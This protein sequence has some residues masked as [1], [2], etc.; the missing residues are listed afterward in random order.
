MRRLSLIL[1]ALILVSNLFSQDSPHGDKLDR[2]CKECHN[3][4]SWKLVKGTYPFDHNSVRFKLEGQHHNV[5]C[6]SCHETLVFNEAKSEC[7]SCHTDMHEQT[8][9]M[10]CAR[11]H[12]PVSWIVSNINEIHEVS[13]FPLLGAHLMA[14]CYSCHT[15]YSAS[16]LNFEPLGVEC[17]D[18]HLNN[19][20]QTTS[21][22]HVSGNFSTDCSECHDLNAFTF[23]GSGIIHD[24][25]PL[26]QG[27]SISDC[28]AC[29][30]EG[31]P[32]SNISAECI[33]CHQSDFN[34]TTNPNHVSADLSTN[35]YDC[36][37]LAKGWKP[38][39]F[40]QHDPLYFPI[41]SGK[42][43]NE[44]NN[45]SD[46]HEVSS[47]YAQYTC[48]S[49]H[50]HNQSEMD[51]KH[52]DVGGYI[53]ES[54]ACLECHPDGNKE[55]FNHNTSNF[56]LTG[57]HITTDC[58]ECH[59]A[60]FAN[61]P[62]N[63]SDCHNND[64]L[65]TT[66]P[67]HND[68]GLALECATCHTTEPTWIPASFDVHNDYYELK[69][70]HLDIANNC[71]ECHN[72]D[73]N[74]TENTCFG[75][76]FLDYN[77][78]NNPPH[79]VSQFSTECITCHTEDAWSPATFDH[80]GLYFPIY[81]GKHEGEWAVCNDCH[82]NP[83]NYSIFSCIVCHLQGEMN[84]KHQGIGGYIFEDNACLACHPDGSSNGFDH[85]TSNF[86]LTGA[87]ITTDCQE[88]HSNG[89]AGTPTNC[90][91]CHNNDYLQ[92]TNPNH[93]SL[94]LSNECA[95][96]HTTNPDWNPAQF[97]NHN[98]FYVLEGAHAVIA[99]NC[100]E[101][102]EGNYNSTP[103]TCF[104]C[105]ADDY[106]QTTNP[107]HS[108]AQ[109]PTTCETC[110]TQNAWEPS[111]WD[112]DAL[113]FPIY[114]GSHNGQWDAC[115]DCHTNPSNYTIFSCTVCHLQGDMNEHHQGISGY[116]WESNACLACHPD[117]NSGG[118]DH[119]NSNFPLTG[120]HTTVDCQECH[121]NGYAGTT[122]VCGDCH[123]N[124]YLQ[125]TNPNHNT[126]GLSNECA[127]C[128][129]TNPNWGP[130]SFPSHN[131][132]Y[133]LQGAHAGIANDCVQC[134]DGNYN[135]TP[136]TCFGCHAENYNLTID[137]S[138]AIALFPTTCETCH[139]QTGWQP[140]T[141]DHDALYFPIYS[142]AHNG[143]WDACSECHTNPSNFSTFSCTGC[144]QQ[145]STNN[146][147]Q[148]VTGYVWESNSCFACH[149]DGNSSGFDHSTSNFPL[150][151]AH[152]TVNCSE[153]HING[154]S[155]TSTV[156][157]DCHNN[158]YL[159]TTNPNHNSLGLSNDCAICHSTNPN[160]SPAGF[161]DHNNYYV[162]QGAHSG[163][164]NDCVDCHNGN[165]NNTP[166]TCFGCHENDY[167]QTTDP[168]HTAAQFPTDCQSCHTQNAWDPSTWDH[169]NMYF[170]IYS[171]KHNNKWNECNDCHIN[172]SNYS[173]FSC[174]VCHSQNSTNSKHNGVNGYVWESNACYACHP[175]GSESLKT[176]MYKEF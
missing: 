87:H 1:T 71:I 95:V 123:S 157:T 132:Y 139:T 126:L 33:S 107:L 48:I 100:F 99:N 51:S 136:N 89:Y 25:F 176:N 143:E 13:R 145:A 112:H 124:N 54:T 2:A 140:S 92:T 42:H 170:P 165:Y 104:G 7:I 168:S 111:T 161:P 151:G 163:I 137:P 117:G 27:H 16:L 83:A 138:H 66:N 79:I 80:D 70:A 98:D 84:N 146:D 32:Y 34:A 144:H 175:D 57:A 61:T 8:V 23:S 130:A 39:T 60:G 156:C 129:S 24:F 119:N 67:N 41:Y 162:L 38:A 78:T 160:W 6:K 118:F 12:T 47:N 81:S 59:S 72:G 46:C 65:Q 15:S 58:L 96:C 109:F 159:Q 45:C 133:V 172:P 106:N 49:C 153:C 90:S 86:P 37:T 55:G 105:H 108:S 44:W 167:N 103:N 82:I 62:I 14:D 110:H 164:A 88:C 29:H 152:T 122:T 149:P 5:N 30:T 56:P 26:E 11:C 131:A 128:H 174:T 155:G 17:I 18:C 76:H 63:C 102:H 171:G 114:S 127:V 73:Y 173:I 91:D 52:N 148:G 125:T 113:Y 28:F 101:C 166:N 134:H 97:P 94:G 50:D 158:I 40:T 135:I 10:D 3:L 150:T 68:L 85:N 75:C 74:A 31:T 120:A 169:D 154:Y 9:G 43:N 22:N 64:Y 142:G 115:T 121:S 116:I 35:C 141:W 21:P 36:H 93:N 53:Y 147:H 4:D 69:G 77:Q 20:N 19:Y